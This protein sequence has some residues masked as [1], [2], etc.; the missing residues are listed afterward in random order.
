MLMIYG[1]AGY[2]ARLIVEQLAKTSLKVMF[3][4]RSRAKLNAL[5]PELIDAEIRVFTLDNPE[6]I[7]R[8]LQGVHTVLN[9]AGPFSKTARLLALACLTYGVHYLD[10]AGEVEEHQALLALHHQ[11][12]ERSVMVM[13]GVGFGCVPT[14]LAAVEAV[15][16]L[17]KPPQSIVIAYETEGEAS[18]GTLE[19]V[20]RGIHLPGVQ[21]REG[22]L[23]PY[24]PG[25][26]QRYLDFGQGKRLVVTNPWRADL[27]AAYQST[28]SPTI[29]TLASFPMPARIMM[30]A[31]RLTSSG[32]G[33]WLIQKLLDSA[34]DGPTEEQRRTGKT[35]VYV[36][37]SDLSGNSCSLRL[38]GPEA[39]VFTALCAAMMVQRV[40]TSTSLPKGFAT[41]SQLLSFAD[42]CAAPGVQV[43][44]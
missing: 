19:S 14:E 4:G 44:E 1:A 3:A 18:K 23:V 29:E 34:A 24:R 17:G 9:C 16:R 25:V 36:E 32:C 38:R 39:Y 12:K 35:W 13:P 26:D 33:Q 40:V 10:L 6:E 37:A 31:P 7:G 42:I 2:T 41:P 11:A 21:R 27:I 28:K 5:V 15:R 30:S 43:I 22:T 8:N 20:L